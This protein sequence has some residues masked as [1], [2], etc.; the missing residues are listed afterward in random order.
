MITSGRHD[1]GPAMWIKMKRKWLAFS[2]LI[3]SCLLVSFFDIFSN[4]WLGIA[5]LQSLA[6]GSVSKSLSS[7]ADSTVIWEANTDW[8][9]GAA[10]L[11]F[12]SRLVVVVAKDDKPGDGAEV[13]E[14]CPED[15]N[16]GISWDPAGL[17]TEDLENKVQVEPIIVSK[18]IYIN[19]VFMLQLILYN[20]SF[21]GF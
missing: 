20:S 2:P 1:Y 8:V 11:E 5:S 13:P 9:P 3:T 21:T 19:C 12:G 15:R 18:T 6:S 16:A 17:S 7:V 14:K 10:A 4:T